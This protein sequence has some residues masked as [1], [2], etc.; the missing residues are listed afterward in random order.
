MHTH[1]RVLQSLIEKRRLCVTT[2]T[3]LQL[4]VPNL[5]PHNPQESVLGNEQAAHEC[6]WHAIDV[7]SE[8]LRANHRTRLRLH[9]NG[10]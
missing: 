1:L 5:L 7:V 9:S 10:H 2:L 8:R 3:S 4:S 6:M